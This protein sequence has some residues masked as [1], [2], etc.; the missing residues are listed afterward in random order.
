MDELDH[1]TAVAQ[2]V[3]QNLDEKIDA[4]FDEHMHNSPVSRDTDV[5]NHVRA[6][7]EK[8][9]AILKS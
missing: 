2:A 4:W 5:L 1:A 8:L 7:V 6:G 3:A 9:K